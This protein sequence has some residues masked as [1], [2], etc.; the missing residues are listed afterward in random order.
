M[1]HS[2]DTFVGE[3][4]GDIEKFAAAYKTKHDENPDHYPLVLGLNNAG[5]WFEFF[6]TF[7]QTGE[8]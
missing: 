7:C 3:M 5:L 8:V 2:L 4:R 6:M 1:D